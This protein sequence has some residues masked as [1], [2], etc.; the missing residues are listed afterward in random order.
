MTDRLPWGSVALIVGT[1]LAV[2]AVGGETPAAD[3]VAA[4][5]TQVEA[6]WLTPQALDQVRGAPQKAT[7]KGPGP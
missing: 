7:R 6:D 2:S 5:R 1:L 3:A 4:W